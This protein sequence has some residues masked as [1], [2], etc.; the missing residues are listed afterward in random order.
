MPSIG[1]RNLRPRFS[2]KQNLE[3]DYP[4]PT[5][6]TL[7]CVTL[8]A[9]IGCPPRATPI[10]ETSIGRTKLTQHFRL[11]R[12]GIQNRDS[13]SKFRLPSKYSSIQCSLSYRVENIPRI[14]RGDPVGSIAQW[15]AHWLLDPAAPGSILRV[16]EIFSEGI[17]AQVNQRCC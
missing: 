2:A 6:L 13:C 8:L 10:Q 3:L 11:F 16:P 15:L 4:I 5:H 14:K 9:K 12:S 17:A 7:S 1:K